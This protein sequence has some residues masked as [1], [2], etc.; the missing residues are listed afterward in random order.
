MCASPQRH[1]ATSAPC[2]AC[3]S[4]SALRERGI[5][6][7][8]AGLDRRRRL[9]VAPP[10]V[11]ALE[12]AFE[13]LAK[14]PPPKLARHSGRPSSSANMPSVSWRVQA[15]KIS[16]AAL[17]P[18]SCRRRPRVRLAAAASGCVDFA[19]RRY[20][21]SCSVASDSLVGL[22]RAQALQAC[23]S[24]APRAARSIRSHAVR[25]RPFVGQVMR[26]VGARGCAGWRSRPSRAPGRSRAASARLEEAGPVVARVPARRRHQALQV[27]LGLAQRH[28]AGRDEAD[29][30]VD[31]GDHHVLHRRLV[32]RR[33]RR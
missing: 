24:A 33:A 5:D 7:L 9:V 8:R 12:H 6:L 18:P 2:A 27:V 32:V 21:S 13:R 4:S 3:S 20:G 19:L 14:A 25:R 17:S 1:A 26:I 30:A 15:Q 31:V 23:A 28:A 10:G 29:V 22:H 16:G 11:V